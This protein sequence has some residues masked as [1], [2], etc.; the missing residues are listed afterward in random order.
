[1]NVTALFVE[2]LVVG[3]GTAT[4]LAL[5]LAAILNYKFDTMILTDNKVLIGTLIAIVYVLGIVMDR[6]IRGIFKYTVEALAK[7]IVF[8]DKINHIKNIAPDINTENLDME[9]EKVIRSHSQPLASKIDYNRSRFRICRAWVFH[10]ILIGISFMCWNARVHVLPLTTALWLL[11]LDFLFLVLT[12]RATRLLA[13]DH[14]KD[15]LESFEIVMI[16]EKIKPER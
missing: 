2:L 15:L 14:Q 13:E 7:W 10:F 11:G 16:A 6:L 8:K 12:W 4:W 3:I 5:F 1:M 9:F